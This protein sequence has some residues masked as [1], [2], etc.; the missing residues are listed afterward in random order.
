MHRE[1]MEARRQALRP[2][3]VGVQEQ[4]IAD[5]QEFILVVDDVDEGPAAHGGQAGAVDEVEVIPVPVAA[6]PPQPMD[7]PMDTEQHQR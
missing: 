5:Q 4:A 2:Q 6:E 1:Q 7:I 3:E